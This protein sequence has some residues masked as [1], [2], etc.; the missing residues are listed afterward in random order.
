MRHTASPARRG[1]F[2]SGRQR[3][4][5]GQKNIRHV[6]ISVLTPHTDIGTVHPIAATN[7]PGRLRRV[8]GDRACADWSLKTEGYREMRRRGERFWANPGLSADTQCN[9]R[10]HLKNSQR[11][12]TCKDEQHGTGAVRRV[13]K[14]LSAYEDR[15]SSALPASLCSSPGVIWRGGGVGNRHHASS[16]GN[17]RAEAAHPGSVES[18]D[19]AAVSPGLRPARLPK[20]HQPRRMNR[21]QGPAPVICRQKKKTAQTRTRGSTNTTCKGWVSRPRSERA[22]LAA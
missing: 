2:A 4:T 1:F 3:K 7:A 13:R 15:R 5:Q 16:A 18:E 9:G 11:P 22:S 19:C 17:R 20:S 10:A 12:S 14:A 8:G 6:P 21:P